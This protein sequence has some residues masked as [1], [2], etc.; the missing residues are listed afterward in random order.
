MKMEGVISDVGRVRWQLAEWYK[1]VWIHLHSKRRKGKAEDKIHPQ[2]QA[3][4]TPCHVLFHNITYSLNITKQSSHYF[5][6]AL[7]L[8][9]AE[10]VALACFRLLSVPFSPQLE[11]EKCLFTLNAIFNT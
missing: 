11:K 8:P 2:I 10:A 5:R 7:A 9:L 6:V 3:E 4:K 1:W